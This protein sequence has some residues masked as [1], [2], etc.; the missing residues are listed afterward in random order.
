MRRCATLLAAV[1]LVLMLWT[2]GTAH[3]A[4]QLDMVPVAALAGHYEGDR[5]EAPADSHKG[6]G[7]HHAPCGEHQFATPA[8]AGAVDDQHARSQPLP[9]QAAMGV[10]GREPVAQLRP[11][12]V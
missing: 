7:H 4:D 6:V 9:D 1:M 11:P 8:A 2:A 5:D 3:A 12:I 10:V